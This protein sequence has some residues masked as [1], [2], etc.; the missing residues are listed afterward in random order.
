MCSTSGYHHPDINLDTSSSSDC[1]TSGKH[2]NLPKLAL[3][4]FDGD[5]MKWSVFWERFQ[6]AVDSN[7]KLDVSH[8]LTY[9]R[10]AIKDPKVTPL[11][12]SGTSSPTQ[13]QE[14]VELLTK[15]YSKKRLIHTN[16]SLNLINWGLPLQRRLKRTSS[17]SL[18]L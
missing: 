8:K 6:A 10:E 13:Y 3:P 1:S 2:F 4:T 16:H 14:L 12:Y 15:R 18:I 17:L 5:P 9:L 11:L 7:D